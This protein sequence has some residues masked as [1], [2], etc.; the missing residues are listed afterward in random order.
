[1]FKVIVFA[2]ILALAVAAPEPKPKPGI[3]TAAYT[4]PVVG[5]PLAYSSPVVS[6]YTSPVVSAYTAPVVSSYST[7]HGAV[8]AVSAY[9][10]PVVYA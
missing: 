10:A 1:M 6:G 3:V 8:P 5:T 4:A 7:Y 9:S 2:A